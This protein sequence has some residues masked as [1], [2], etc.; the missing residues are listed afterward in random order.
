MLNKVVL[1]GRLVDDPELRYTDDG[2]PFTI[3][4]LAVDRNYTNSKGEKETDFI[5][6]VTWRRSAENCSQFLRKGIMAAVDGSFQIR[7]NEN[8]EKTYYNPQIVANSV[9]F[10]EWPDQPEQKKAD[11]TGDKKIVT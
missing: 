10:L 4:T 5:D 6:I 7:K 8:E 1:I 3:F 2:T 11:N 9:S